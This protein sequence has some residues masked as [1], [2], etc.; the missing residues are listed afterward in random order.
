MKYFFSLLAVFSLL[1]TGAALAGYDSLQ[2]DFDS[3]QPK[4]YYTPIFAHEKGKQDDG[5]A[6]DTTFRQQIEQLKTLK[7]EWQDSLAD[8]AGHEG[9]FRP[10]LL[11]TGQLAE[12]AAH[13]S[14][15]AALLADRFT[16]DDLE[17][18]ALFRNPAIKSAED[19]A[20]AAVESIS[21]ISELDAILYR[22]TAFTESLMSGIGPMKG[23]NA[24]KNRFPFPGLTA[25]KGGIAVQEV[26]VARQ[27][28]EIARRSV[29]TS[30]RRGYWNLLFT[31][32]AIEIQGDTV[33]LLANLEAVAQS[34][35]E[36]GDTGFADLLQVRIKRQLMEDERQ[37]LVEK[38]LTLEAMVL[39]LLNL[40]PETAVGI[41][42][43]VEVNGI[44]VDLDTLYRMALT[45]RQEI[46][47][48][49]AQIVKMEKMVELGETMILPPFT[50]GFSWF[51]DEAA[52]QVGSAAPQKT[53]ATSTSASRG[54]GLPMNPWYGT[55]DS[56]LN[57]S[58]FALMALKNDLKRVEKE[59]IYQVRAAWFELDRAERQQKLYTSSVVELSRAAW[60]VSSR[61]YGTG[62]VPFAT[63]MGAHG[64][65]LKTMIALARATSDLA[66]ARSELEAAI[67]TTLP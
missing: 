25:L 65:W 4:S 29:L 18:L 6:G 59:T 46:R 17:I 28:L 11:K 47:Q 7:E 61:G 63:V 54:A 23:E 5:A 19:S 48:K 64:E 51:E 50:L 62:S 30:L 36:S 15:T 33:Q 35:Y 67:G 45:N 31:H 27:Q 57:R 38:K 53:F 32:Q 3:Y 42:G 58:R 66:I 21:Q 52:A 2:K 12:T 49:Q 14:T 26:T 56:Y 41:P 37:T 44:A 60:E 22:Y 13:D 9:F 39:Q 43:G 16:V 55:S 8:P 20:R 40:P 34:R 10:E 1:N 24:V